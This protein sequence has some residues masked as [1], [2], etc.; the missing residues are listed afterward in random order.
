MRN[1][2]RSGWVLGRCKKVQRTSVSRVCVGLNH[3]ERN[4]SWLE[5]LCCVVSP[6]P[7]LSR[8]R[9]AGPSQATEEGQWGEKKREGK[10]G[11]ATSVSLCGG[12]KD[13]PR[14]S[15]QSLSIGIPKQDSGFATASTRFPAA[16]NPPATS[17]LPLDPTGQADSRGR[18]VGVGVHGSKAASPVQCST[19]QTDGVQATESVGY[20]LLSLTDFFVFFGF[21]FL[22]NLFAHSPPQEL[23]QTEPRPQSPHTTHTRRCPAVCITTGSAAAHRE[24]NDGNDSNPTCQ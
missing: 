5:N 19:R 22:N 4:D 10:R 8:G 23:L 17:R 6:L 1:A 7:G 9:K 13:R 2:R 18:Q 21:L 20:P 12:K 15:A 3:V 11:K 14:R 16:R 24:Q